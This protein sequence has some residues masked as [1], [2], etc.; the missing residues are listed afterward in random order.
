MRYITQETLRSRRPLCYAILAALCLGTVV[1]VVHSQRAK[2]SQLGN[3][4]IASSS[5]ELK[6]TH[7]G[8]DDGWAKELSSPPL[9][10][11]LSPDKIAIQAETA[12]V[13]KVWKDGTLSFQVGSDFVTVTP[14]G[15]VIYLPKEL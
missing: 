5:L 13:H 8:R 12:R 9:E 7:S 14:E 10:P 15:E 4:T 1:W 2:P 3:H 6:T 11:T